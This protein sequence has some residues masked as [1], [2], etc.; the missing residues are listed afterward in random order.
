MSGA[1]IVAVGV[2]SILALLE[3]AVPMLPVVFRQLLAELNDQSSADPDD[4]ED[5]EI[6]IAQPK[7]AAQRAEPPKSPPRKAEAPKPA[8]QGDAPPRPAVSRPEVP[9]P[10]PPSEPPEGRAPTPRP[11]P[12]PEAAQRLWEEARG[13][14]HLFVPDDE[15]D[16]DYLEKV[17]AAAELGHVEAMAKLGDYAF[18]R[19]M[20]VEAFYWRWRA[21]ANGWNRKENPT[22]REIR[23]AWRMEGCPKEY[24]N[25]LDEDQGRF[26]RALL[27]VQCG[28]DVPGA[29]RRLKEMAEQ[30]FAD[31][32]QF[33]SR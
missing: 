25:S 24:E 1:L 31:A 3:T 12:N 26:A 18:R 14:M 7:P 4:A 27:R 2:V 6:W 9:E 16:H 5:E 17:R 32:R 33:F 29:R 8:P 11:A 19:M 30:G 28:I 23:L 10:P 15:T 21:E 13:M 20:F 22:L